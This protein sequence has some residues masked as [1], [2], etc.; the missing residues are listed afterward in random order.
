[1]AVNQKRVSL[2]LGRRISGYFGGIC[3]G[4]ASLFWDYSGNLQS[5]ATF[6]GLRPSSGA[7]G[8]KKR[9]VQGFSCAS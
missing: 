8:G 5:P 7:A 2:V 3:S 9:P 1:M 4:M 6:S